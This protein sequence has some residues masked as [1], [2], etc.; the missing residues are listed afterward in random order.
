M[1]LMNQGGKKRMYVS[2]IK[3]EEEAKLS[4]CDLLAFHSSGI[5]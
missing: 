5:P 2:L 4:R 3:T 1:K